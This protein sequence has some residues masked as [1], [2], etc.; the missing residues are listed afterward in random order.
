MR[1]LSLP[2]FGTAPSI[3]DIDLPAPAAGEILVK[4]A[5][6]SVNGFDGMVAAGYLNGM[7]DHRFPVVLGKDFAGKVE[8][9][10]DGVTAFAVGD[11]VFGV[12]TKSFLCDGSFGE[13]VTVPVSVGVAALPD[14]VEF[15]VGA[16][17][18]LA[19][20]TA[21]TAVAAAELTAGSVV[22]VTGATGGVGNQSVQLAA[23]TGAHVIATG[24][25]DEGRALVV[26]LGAD[27]AI[28][29]TAGLTDAVLASHPDG[30]DAVLH[31][32]GDPVAMLPL[33]K[34]GGRFVSALVQSPEQLPSDTVTVVP[35]F[36]NPTP[37]TLH[38]LAA[39]QESGA[40]RVVVQQ[41]YP[42]DAA[43]DALADF[44]NGTLGNLVIAV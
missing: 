24:R 26:D 10:G 25:T 23:A 28:D 39:D 36:A 31:F 40:T 4:V 42:L 15:A 33:V 1:A 11:R 21:A 2:N 20:T 17:L 32:A 9:V 14:G 22:L 12:V 29:Y 7:M 43:G 30:V 6:A 8:A 19:G 16:A 3:T 35:V 34:V 5:A 37:E 44:G 38:R 41:T 18:G 27:E 13:Y